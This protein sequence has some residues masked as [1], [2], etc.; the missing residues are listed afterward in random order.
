LRF[1]NYRH[2]LGLLLL[3]EL[4]VLNRSPGSFRARWETQFVKG[5][6]CAGS[7]GLTPPHQMHQID[8]YWAAAAG[9]KQEGFVCGQ[10]FPFTTFGKHPLAYKSEGVWPNVSLCCRMVDLLRPTAGTGPRRPLHL[11]SEC[12]LVGAGEGWET[13]QHYW[14]YN[15]RPIVVIHVGYASNVRPLGRHE[16]SGTRRKVVYFAP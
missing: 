5:D 2:V 3:E 6:P 11:V 8:R 13:G 7:F 10:H 9:P 16:K 14:R 15:C 4:G 1:P 12:T